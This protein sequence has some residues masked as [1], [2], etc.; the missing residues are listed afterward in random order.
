MGNC[1]LG[2]GGRRSNHSSET[3]GSSYYDVHRHVDRYDHGGRTRYS[4]SQA[5]NVVLAAPAP[6]H[7]RMGGRRPHAHYDQEGHYAAESIALTPRPGT[8]GQG[9]RDPPTMWAYSANPN[10]D[11]HDQNR[12]GRPRVPGNPDA[13]P[14]RIITDRHQVVQ[15]MSY[16][17]DGDETNFVRAKRKHRRR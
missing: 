2:G 4:S 10:F 6:S 7:N 14:A 11:H 17:P 8:T 1:C 3:S 12:F 16:H 15:G 5:A 13:G 9:G